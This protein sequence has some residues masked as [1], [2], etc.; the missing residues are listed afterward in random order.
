MNTSRFSKIVL[1]L[2]ILSIAAAIVYV[3]SAI[4][5][6]LDLDWLQAPKGGPPYF[7][8]ATAMA[9][10]EVAEVESEITC[11]RNNAIVKAVQKVSPSVVSISTVQVQIV[12]DPWYDF[13]YP[14]N[15][16]M[17]R[18]HYGLGSGVIIDKRG[19]ILTNQHVIADADEIKATLP[20]GDEF[21]AKI[22]GSDYES[23]LAVL[24]VNSGCF[25]AVGT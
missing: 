20:N 3:L 18:L 6:H 12:R 7:V 10:D 21:E 11:S 8:E 5:G 17:K 25:H 4:T 2:T 1:S 19:Y 15:P 9:A 24:K 13:F 14:S 23:D 22:V 16:G